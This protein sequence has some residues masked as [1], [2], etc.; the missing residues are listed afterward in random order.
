MIRKWLFLMDSMLVF[1]S[2][3][4]FITK[5]IVESQQQGLDPWVA[6]LLLLL[7]IIIIAIFMI[8]FALRTQKSVAEAGLDHVEHEP[9]AAPEAPALEE[10]APASLAA[11]PGPEIV[12]ETQAAET[13]LEPTP[14]ETPAEPLEAPVAIPVAEA[15]PAIPDDLTM[16]EGIGPKISSVLQAAGITTFSQL[17]AADVDQLKQLM[18]SANLRLADPAS[19]PQQAAYLAAGDSDKFE[20]LKTRL[21]GGKIV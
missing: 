17:A 3:S 7:I 1:I 19:W 6:F 14:E 10:A 15:A 8:L 20:E 21:R 18:L 9:E 4:A 5:P 13:Q 2:T 16:I 12:M 11:A